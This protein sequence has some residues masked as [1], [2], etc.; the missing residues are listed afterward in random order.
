M[1]VDQ[2]RPIALNKAV[3]FIGRHA[4]CDVILSRSRKVSRKHCC[5]A[6]VND[7]LVVRDLGSLNGVRVNGKRVKKESDLHV[8]DEVAIGDCRYV[9]TCDYSPPPGRP[10]DKA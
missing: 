5:V 9:V 7:R 10:S 1:S 3:V 6:Q 8:G 2:G 4:E